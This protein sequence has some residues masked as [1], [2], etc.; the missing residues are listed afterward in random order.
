MK[1]FI[2]SA[3]ALCL[4]MQATMAQEKAEEPKYVRSSLTTIRV[5]L[6]AADA[7]KDAMITK[8]YESNPVPERY[9]D[10]RFN[11][12]VIDFKSLPA[13]TKEEI[14]A[15]GVKEN[16]IMEQIRKFAEKMAA[17]PSLDQET[18]KALD[19]FLSK[20]SEGEYVVKIQKWLKEQQIANKL[21]A[22]WHSPIT[23]ANA[24]INPVL[25]NNLTLI[26]DWGLVNLSEEAKALV[27]LG[28]GSVDNVATDSEVDLINKTYVTVNVLKFTPIEEMKEYFNA[29]K[30]I[31]LAQKLPAI[32]LAPI[33]NW[34]EKQINALNGYMINTKTFLFQL[35]WNKELYTNFYNTYW[36]EDGLKNCIS[37]G[38]YGLKYIGYSSKTSKPAISS[39]KSEEELINVATTRAMDAN[40]AKL[41]RD[42]EQFRPMFSLHEVDGKLVA[43]LGLKEGIKS[44]DTFEVY[45]KQVNKK[46]NAEEWTVIGKIKVSKGG[47]WDNRAGADDPSLTQEDDDDE[48]TETGAAGATY[49]VFDGKP[50]KFGE[51]CLIKLAGK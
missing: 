29:M 40:Y 10:F 12:G 35:E 28:G 50:G 16:K 51:G 31:V 45:Q 26:H 32:A 30:T 4:S 27:K 42:Y 33:N 38:N 11:T 37:S 44:G 13:V 7:T 24:D 15:A 8:A 18:K 2:M 39:K 23:P 21:V 9:N 48:K 20:P 41:Q 34:I 43:Y 17:D 22:K 14:A 3:L 1:T 36:T 46:T 6:D 19:A 5:S 25:D 47:V 49:T